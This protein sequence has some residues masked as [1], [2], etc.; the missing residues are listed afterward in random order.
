MLHIINII[1]IINIIKH[2]YNV[3][4]YKL[5]IVIKSLDMTCTFEIDAILYIKTFVVSVRGTKKILE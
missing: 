5:I 2:Y 3:T 4:I 1:I